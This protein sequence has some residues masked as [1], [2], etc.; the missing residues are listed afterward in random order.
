[1]INS[2]YYYILKYCQTQNVTIYHIYIPCIFHNVYGDLEMLVLNKID[3][4]FGLACR[5]FG[6]KSTRRF[7]DTK[8][9]HIQ[10]G[11]GI[12]AVLDVSPFWLSPFWMCRR[13]GCRRFGCFAVLDVSPFWRVAVLVVAVLDL[14]PF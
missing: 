3:H 9:R 4:Y 14:S 11:D 6:Y 1:M 12:P 5:R 8:R 13:F 7:G 10:N 2:I